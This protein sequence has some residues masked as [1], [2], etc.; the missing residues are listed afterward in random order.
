MTID[1]SPTARAL[2][3]LEA[4]Q[5][6]PGITAERLGDR[7]G[8]SSARRTPL[9]RD[10]ARGRHPGRVGARTRA[11]GYRLGRGV[12]PPPLLFGP[13]EVLG[14]VMAALDGQHDAADVRGAGRSCARQAAADAAHA[15]WPP[16]P[17]RYV[18]RRRYPTAARRARS[19]DDGR[20]GRGVRRAP[21]GCG[22]ATGPR[23][24]AS[25][26]PRSSRGRSRFATAA[27]TSCAARCAADAV[28]TYR[29][30]RVR[31]V[32]ASRREVRATRGPRPGGHAWRRTSPWAGSTTSA[33]SSTPRWSRLQRC[34]PRTMGRLEAV[35]AT[36]TR[37][38]AST[39]QPDVLRRAAG[40]PAGRLPDRG[41]TGAADR[42]RGARSAAAAVGQLIAQG[43]RAATASGTAG[44]RRRGAPARRGPAS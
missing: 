12:R 2:L 42:G 9:R 6:S 21:S 15:R 18:V 41:G 35:D 31:A 22:W 17:R 39:E 24:G 33:C 30:D 4:L 11:G 27:G 3:A 16:R 23:A 10:P 8:V 13:D 20:A 26:R 28:R 29:I 14:L 1:A 38:V 44:R 7:L 19:R 5:D 40:H 43:P 36:T 32:R 37:L 34:V 25:G